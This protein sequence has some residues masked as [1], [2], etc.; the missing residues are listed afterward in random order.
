MVVVVVFVVVVAGGSDAWSAAATRVNGVGTNRSVFDDG[1]DGSAA[2]ARGASVAAT[3]P[4]P[5]GLEG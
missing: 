3:R 5:G 4:L 1:A 2:A